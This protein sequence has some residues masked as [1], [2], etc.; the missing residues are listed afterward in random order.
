MITS[1]S[2]ISNGIKFTF[3]TTPSFRISQPLKI[4]LWRIYSH[5]DRGIITTNLCFNEDNSWSACNANE[6]L[7]ND[8]LDPK[9]KKACVGVPKITIIPITVFGLA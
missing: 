2:Y 1:K 6:V 3:N 5:R 8:L 4:E 7:T 9:S